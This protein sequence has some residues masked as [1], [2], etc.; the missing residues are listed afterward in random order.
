MV[1]SVDIYIS[2]C[3]IWGYCLLLWLNCVDR[4]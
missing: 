2:V 1:V 3:L 4:L